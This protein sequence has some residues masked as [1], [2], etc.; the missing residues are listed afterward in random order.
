MKVRCFEI[1]RRV[2]EQELLWLEDTADLERAKSRIQELAFVW[3]GEFDVMDRS[4][5]QIVAKV[6]GPVDELPVER[7]TENGRREYVRS[8]KFKD[9]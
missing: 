4:S 2:N 1:V 9:P 6:V 5:H 3:P 7:P 8:G